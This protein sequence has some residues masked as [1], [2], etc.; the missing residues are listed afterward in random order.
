MSTIQANLLNQ[1]RLWKE[2]VE[3]GLEEEQ[4]TI[5][6]KER[7]SRESNLE[8]NAGRVGVGWGGGCWGRKYTW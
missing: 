3:L 8:E 4:L 2:T 1:R 6:I 5:C 7:G